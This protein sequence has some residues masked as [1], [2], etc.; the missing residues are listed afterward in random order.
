MT[1]YVRQALN[2]AISSR[3][4]TTCMTVKDMQDCRISVESQDG[5]IHS[6]DKTGASHIPVVTW[7]R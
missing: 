1:S 6:S 7:K 3:R 2:E 5:H 4:R